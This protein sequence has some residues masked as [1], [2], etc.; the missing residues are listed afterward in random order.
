MRI[1]RGFLFFLAMAGLCGAQTPSAIRFRNGMLDTSLSVAIRMMDANAEEAYVDEEGIAALQPSS[2]DGFIPVLAQFS[3]P[4]TI[5]D[6]KALARGGATVVNYVPDQALLLLIRSDAV[7]ALRRM[8]GI[9]WIGAYP[10]EMKL[11]EALLPAPTSGPA[12]RMDGAGDAV[13]EVVIS[14]LR[15][16]YVHV[17]SALVEEDLGGEVVETGSGSR[18]GTVRAWVAVSSLEEVA[19]RSEVEWIEPYLQPELN[20]NVAVGSEL[21]NVR[22]VWT[23][24]GL[25]G[26]GQIVAVGDSGLDTGNPATIH[27]DFSNRIHAAFGLVSSN[28]WS[29]YNGHGTHT[30]GSVLGNGAAYSNGLFRGVAYEAELVIQAMGSTSG[31][32]GIYVPSPLTLLFTQAHSN[33]ARIHSDSWGGDANGAYDSMARYVDEF[34]WDTDDML[35]V[36]SAGNSG[37]DANQD[38]VIDLGSM[39]SPGT[40]KNC[41]TVGAAETDRPAGSGG[42]S[43]DPWGKGSW[44]AHYPT[45]P[46]RDD[47]ISTSWDG[48][49]QG[50]A[51]FSS[52]G[53]CLDQRIK[54]DIVAPG[55]DVISCRSHQ[56]GAG[57]LW[58]TG[59]G[60]LANNA[61]NDYCFSGGTSM[62]TPLTSGSAALARQYLVEQRGLANPSAALLKG[63]LINGARSLSPGQY[64]T[65]EFLAVPARPNNVE[66]WGHVDLAE[67]LFPE[68]GRAILLADRHYLQTGLTNRYPVVLTS[69]APL[70]VTLTWSDYPAA[71]SSA[72]QLVND[73]D[74]RLVEPD[75][76]VIHPNGS[77][78]P[79]HTN[80]VEGLEVAE[81]KIG[82]NWIEVSGFNV[83]QGPQPCALIIKT[84]GFP[85]PL[86][87]LY[88]FSIDPANPIE[89]EQAKV[90]V[91]VSTLAG[92]LAAVVTSYRVNSNAWEHLLMTPVETNDWVV[93]YEGL[94]PPFEAGDVVDYSLYAMTFEFQFAFSATNQ[95]L[96]SSTNL[97]VAPG[98]ASQWPYNTWETAYTN[99]QQALDGAVDGFVITV[100]NGV[101]RENTLI[102]EKDVTLHSVN[103]AVQTIIDGQD[104]RICLALLADGAWVEGFTLYRGY[105][106]DGGGV[107]MQG[108]T[109]SSS[110][111]DSCEAERY[112]GG[113]YLVGGTVEDCIV[114]RCTANRYAGGILIL[115]GLVQ[116][117]LIYDNVSV[118]D[119]GGMEFW[120]GVVSNCTVAFNQSGGTGGGI[121][122]GDLGYVYNT[123]IV[124]NTAVA[125]GDNWYEWTPKDF[126][127]CCTSP[128][129]GAPGGLD[130]DPLFVNADSRDLRLK[131]ELGHYVDGGGWSN[132]AVT[133]PCIDMGDPASDYSLEP[134]PNGTRINLGAYGGS[135]QASK[136]DTNTY[137]IVVV[138]T[139][140]GADPEPG[141]YAHP[142]GAEIS[143]S[144][145]NPVITGTTTQYVG[146]GWALNGLLDLAG[147]SSGTDTVVSLTLTNS[148]LLTWLWQT[149]VFGIAYAHPHGTVS[150]ATGE[151][152]A[153][154]STMSILAHPETYYGFTGW[155]GTT[156]SVANPFGVTMIRAQELWAGFTPLRTSSGVPQWWLAQY[157]W[158]NDFETAVAADSDQDGAPTGDEYFAGTI[159]TNELS[160][161]HLLTTGGGEEPVMLFWRAMADRTYTLQCST[162]LLTGLTNSL[163]NFYTAISMNMVLEDDTHTNEQS[164][165][166]RI[167]VR[168]DE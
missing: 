163:F 87:G 105:A 77:T 57:V 152:Y 53:P 25:T 38:G 137:K 160:V 84:D 93:A 98:G 26:A 97:F 127:Y 143:C 132:D 151:W 111:V 37:E 63:L 35:V 123:I 50:M 7:P 64:G 30:S 90:Q 101:Y 149:N 85:A 102:V 22:Q 134:A 108:G 83:P 145:T 44:L 146:Q 140:G 166:Y 19:A 103:G 135:T 12:L 51:A 168:Y 71:L 2:L 148:G 67:S 138:S 47:L 116:H 11:D 130:L 6:R 1:G 75:G 107:F 17:I 70:S 162:N 76:T 39:G 110:V 4:I 115:G 86:L 36:F 74:L 29:D 89:Y 32:S 118:S 5:A 82:T 95:L 125:G 161:L 136:G 92:G 154:N 61:S 62:S 27:P 10:A 78:S 104:V 65:D 49:N 94:L 117:S 41:L 52:R 164:L 31:G 114:K 16:R 144:L 119:G 156:S 28:D 54:P 113:I 23:N 3:R 15:P 159:P 80:N 99:I 126:R 34:M 133:S 66:G 167:K 46:I 106:T 24:Y 128:N 124:S 73:L 141:I 59:T 96:V 56:T 121:D 69:T 72:Q 150:G 100:T 131:S 13:A 122:V 79:D 43:S 9:R 21:M 158:T 142:R 18:W 112:G 91:G 139:H 8:E 58:G 155:T 33:E 165:Y 81:G 45:N 40:A 20:N 109:L 157:G 48:T 68:D 120:G 153:L 42:Y 55:T 14:V 147:E 129:P 88:G 60:I